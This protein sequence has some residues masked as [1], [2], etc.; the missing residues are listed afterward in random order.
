M[1]MA[2]LTGGYA[3]WKTSLRDMTFTKIGGVSAI[4]QE[5]PS[6]TPLFLERFR[7]QN[8]YVFVE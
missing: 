8:Q 1:Q 4:S 2:C 5:S 7:T 6:M 3:V